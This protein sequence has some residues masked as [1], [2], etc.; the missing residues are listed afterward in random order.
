MGTG[1]ECPGYDGLCGASYQCKAAKSVTGSADI[2]SWI[3][4]KYCKKD[5]KDAGGEGY[6]HCPYYEPY[7]GPHI[8]TAVCRKLFPNAKNYEYF[9]ASLFRVKQENDKNMKQFITRYNEVGPIL[10]HII[11]NDEELAKDIYFNTI[12]PAVKLFNTGKSNEALKIFI[13]R[14]RDLIEKVKEPLQNSINVINP[15]LVINH[16]DL[17]EQPEQ[18]DLTSVFVKKLELKPQR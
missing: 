5:Y 10:A 13:K 1:I 3:Y 12:I 16:Q 14:V 4:A 2:P 17:P 9:L 6:G 11:E 7:F 8:V 15:Y 18:K